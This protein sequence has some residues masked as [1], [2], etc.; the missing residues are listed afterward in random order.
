MDKE[1]MRRLIHYARI[2]A[3]Y[4]GLKLSQITVEE[5]IKDMRI[6]EKEIFAYALSRYL[7]G[8]NDSHFILIYMLY[9]LGGGGFG[10]C[11]PFE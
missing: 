10:C 8:Q 3:K 2:R 1:D 5:C 9:L 4:R 6:W 7:E 11:S